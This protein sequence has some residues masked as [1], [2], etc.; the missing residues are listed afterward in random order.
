M[1]GVIKVNF[2]SGVLNANFH[3]GKVLSAVGYTL[4]RIEYWFKVDGYKTTI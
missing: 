3:K 1:P 4:S 2:K